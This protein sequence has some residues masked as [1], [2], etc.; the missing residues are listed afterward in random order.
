MA[1]E[2]RFDGRVAIIT[3]AGGQPPS[4][5]AAYAK[6]LASRGAK[7]VVNDLGVGPWGW[8]EDL[9]AN[10]QAVVD[11]IRAAGGDAIG[12]TH[13]C[14]EAESARAV[15]QT[16]LDAWGRV[17][18]LI[19][20]AGVAL[21]AFFYELSEGDIGRIH[22]SSLFGHIWMTRAVWPHMREAG[23]GRI[24]NIPSRAATGGP[25]L[26][27]YG[28]A[29]AGVIGLTNCLALECGDYDIKINGVM[30]EAMT[31]KREVG[32]ADG[33]G[34]AESTVAGHE[35]EVDT[36]AQVVA[37]L[38]HERCEPN[39]ATFNVKGSSGTI[40]EYL[41]YFT[42]GYQNPDLTIE[43]VAANIDRARDRTGATF[44]SREYPPE[45]FQEGWR[46]PYVPH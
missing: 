28:A 20:N 25:Q 45:R 16:A 40:V 41:P 2:L 19:N 35:H 17:D 26:A 12:D 38:C 39:G 13:S 37:Y 24:V 34:S 3:G 21:E 42:A 10:A 18:I 46:R 22:G 43:D 31:K 15:V 14:S 23:Y 44:Y 8:G 29:K 36:V 5:G 33:F 4:L 30:P 9:P 6:L 32:R 7:I 11:E 1:E 27:V